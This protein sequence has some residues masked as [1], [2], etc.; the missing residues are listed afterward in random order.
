MDQ[1]PYYGQQRRRGY[2]GAQQA[3]GAAA[4]DKQKLVERQARKA[5]ASEVSLRIYQGPLPDVP[6]KVK[7]F[8]VLV[9][10]AREL[11]PPELRIPVPL[12][13]RV[14]LDDAEPSESDIE[15][16]V[17]AADALEELWRQGK[18]ILVTCA[19]GLNRSGLVTGLTLRNLGYTGDKAVRAIRIARGQKALSNPWFEAIVRGA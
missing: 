19:M 3:R 10:C 13:L 18:F 7:G 1:N 12:V 11:Q 5:G 4:Y 16:A 14:P 2:Y 9:L 6:S 15:A 8:D 17:A